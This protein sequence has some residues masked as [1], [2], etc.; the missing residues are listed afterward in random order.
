[1]MGRLQARGRGRRDRVP[2]LPGAAPHPL[3]RHPRGV[4]LDHPRRPRRVRRLVRDADGLARHRARRGTAAA[5]AFMLFGQVVWAV[6]FST[7]QVAIYRRALRTWPRAARLRPAGRA[8]RSRTERGSERFD[9]RAIVA[10]AVVATVLLLAEPQLAAARRRHRLA[11]SRRGCSRGPTATR[12]RSASRSR[13]C[14]PSPR[15]P[16]GCSAAPASSS[17]SSASCAPCCSSRSRPGCAPPPAP[18]GCARPSGGCSSSVR[19]IPSVREAVDVLGGLDPG[20]R[21]IAAGRAAAARF[22]EV[23]LSPRRSRTRSSTGWRRSPW[24]TRPAARPRPAALR[25]AGR[26]RPARRAHAGPGAGV[27]R[28]ALSRAAAP[29]G[30]P[31]R[32]A[33][34][35]TG[36][37]RSGR[38]PPG[39]SIGSTPS[40]L[41]P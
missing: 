33:P 8:R 41:A 37:W 34:R 11:R 2:R 15:S 27:A 12:C 39:I 20:P 29:R 30:E 14:S 18:A 22:A 32:G 25:A 23:D 28:R 19:W 26:R 10:A 38:A 21:L 17:R 36:V 40:S 31:G 9:P 13:G 16:A 4:H 7:V 24:P 35:R 1:M 5:I 3:R 6:F